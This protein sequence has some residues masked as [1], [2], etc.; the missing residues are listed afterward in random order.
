[1]CAVSQSV[2]FC[3]WDDD[4]LLAKHQTQAT[5]KALVFQRDSCSI[6]SALE[7][8]FLPNIALIFHWFFCPLRLSKCYMPFFLNETRVDSLFILSCCLPGWS[9][10]QQK[11]F[12]Y[13]WHS[14]VA[15]ICLC[16]T[17]R[18]SE[19]LAFPSG[20]RQLLVQSVVFSFVNR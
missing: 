1:M 20:S 6:S 18:E 19:D 4:R 9:P 16:I 2:A 7:S 15:C 13:F 5:I 10:D 17:C 3:I 8:I 11:F 14:T 12:R